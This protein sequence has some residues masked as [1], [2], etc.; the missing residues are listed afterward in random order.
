MIENECNT[1]YGCLAIIFYQK[2]IF[3][4]DEMDLRLFYFCVTI[5]YLL[6][7]FSTHPSSPLLLSQKIF[8]YDHASIAHEVDYQKKSI[9]FTIYL[10]C[11]FCTKQLTIEVSCTEPSEY[12]NT[13][14][15]V[16]PYNHTFK[17]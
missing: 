10:R 3:F 17:N 6:M 5:Y 13:F 12:P 11:H 8:L 7:R 1:T 2:N 14:P 9:C 16:L 4:F 15:L